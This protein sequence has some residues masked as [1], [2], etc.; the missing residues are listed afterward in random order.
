MLK[1]IT[2]TRSLPLPL[3]WLLCPRVTSL[4]CNLNIPFILL[5]VLTPTTNSWPITASILGYIINIS[6]CSKWIFE[7]WVYL[8]FPWHTFLLI[9]LLQAPLT[10][11]IPS[12]LVCLGCHNKT[13]QTWWL[14]RQ[15]SITSQFWQLEDG[16]LSARK[17]D[18]WWDLSSW[19][20]DGCLLNDANVT[21]T[22]GMYRES[23]R[24]SPSYKDTIPTG[25][26]PHP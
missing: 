15:T 4:Y 23:P 7:F 13:S 14:K 18:C 22:L 5:P 25:L 24:V 6:F 16:Y 19:P 21:F 12:V 2:W 1:S 17:L 8:T 10:E 9:K 3:D 20:A 11:P 26:E